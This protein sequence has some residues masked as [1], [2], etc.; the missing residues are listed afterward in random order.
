MLPPLLNACLY[1]LLLLLPLM[2][3]R[4]YLSQS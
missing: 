3:L 2:L 1:L 4:T